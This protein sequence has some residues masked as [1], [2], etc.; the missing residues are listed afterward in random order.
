MDDLPILI[1]REIFSFLSL[2]E[3]LKCKRVSKQWKFVVE[4]YP[5][6]TRF[7]CI[8]REN[9]PY[10]VKWCFSERDVIPE[11]MFFYDPKKFDNFNSRIDLF[12]NLQNLYFF[13]VVM[14]KQFVRDL[15]LLRNLKV[16]MI[17]NFWKLHNANDDN[18]IILNLESLEKL[19][20]KYFGRARIE[21]IDFNTPNLSSLIFWNTCKDFPLIFRFPL[22]IRHL[23]CIV[24]N[25]DMSTLK[26]LETL[27]CQKIVCPLELKDF[28]WLQR[29][30]LF[31]R[32]ETE[33]EYIRGIMDQKN[34]LRRHRLQIIVCGL[35][36]TLV[37]CKRETN[38]QDYCSFTLN[39]DYFGKI[40]EHQDK[41]VGHIPWEFDLGPDLEFKSF[42][43]SFKEI[44]KKFFKQFFNLNHI[45]IWDDIKRKREVYFNP[46]YAIKLISQ[47]NPKSV[48]I[49]H[50]F[51]KK[52]YE[53][54]TSVQSIKTLVVEDKFENINYDHFLNL[55]YLKSLSVY[56]ERLPIS[57]IS[58]V[59]KLKFM[60]NFTFHCSTCIISF[61]YLDYRFRP[62]YYSFNV[63]IRKEKI[64]DI[65]QCF[66]C[67][68]DLIEGFKFLTM[69]NMENKNR[70]A[71]I[72]SESL[73]L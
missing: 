32:E 41:L 52:F 10:K 5:Q 25:S 44:P 28:K 61:S 26:N 54:L 43:N 53:Q 70:A 50:K 14:N 67:L 35:K 45:Y 73:C 20:F 59:L 31:P 2:P 46:D 65:N 19:S 49:N 36:D 60:T 15:N 13:H 16:L 22:S 47:S 51:N 72:A 64:Q 40:V 34:D 17:E 30:E 7:L 3:R 37:V 66:K 12:R 21:S 33:L 4:T 23:E 6:D 71:L 69:E 57:F 39:N 24:F 9:F 68:D 55:S 11:D 58:K 8:Y 27:V 62:G 29:L 63:E 56:T 38:L 18:R 1:L 42:Y 48:D